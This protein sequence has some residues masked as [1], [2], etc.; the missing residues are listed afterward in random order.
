MQLIS[1]IGRQLLSTRL[2]SAFLPHLSSPLKVPP[3][4]FTPLSSRALTHRVTPVGPLCLHPA[5]CDI[6][7]AKLQKHFGVK[8]ILL[9]P[10]KGREKVQV[11]N[12]G[13]PPEKKLN[14]RGEPACL[15]RGLRPLLCV[16]PSMCMINCDCTLDVPCQKPFSR[17]LLL[18]FAE[19]FS[20]FFSLLHDGADVPQVHRHRQP[21]ATNATEMTDS[22]EIWPRNGESNKTFFGEGV[23][24]T[25][26]LM[27]L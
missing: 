3:P 26:K 21:P 27:T 11:S 5:Y 25:R 2:S 9:K 20:F 4:L 13:A 8:V 6:V 23:G 7:N 14:N 19:S 16:F 18:F 15:R 22:K 17:P 12:V 10:N 1:V 24:G